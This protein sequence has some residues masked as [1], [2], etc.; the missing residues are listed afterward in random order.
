MQNYITDPVLKVSTSMT[1][2]RNVLMRLARCKFVQKKENILITGSTG[3]E[4]SYLGT[5]VDYEGCVEDFKV[6]YFNTSKLFAKIKMAK[7]DGSYLR[8]I[9]KIPRQDLIILDDFG[10]QAFDSANRIT[11]L[12]I[13]EDRHN[14]GF[15]IVTSQIPIQDWYD[16]IGEKTIADDILDKLN[17]HSHCLELQ[18]ESIRKKKRVNSE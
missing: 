5:A 18:K 11:I 2:A 4:K 10:L 1:P 8:E 12:E 17:H 14:K 15:I 9:A 3:V 7:A 16:I 13:I 6:N